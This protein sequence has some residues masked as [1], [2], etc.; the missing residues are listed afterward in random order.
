VIVPIPCLRDNYAYLVT[1]P[2]TFATAIVDP[3]ESA[4]VLA[5][6]AKLS[7]PPA[8]I[9]CTHHHPDHVGGNEELVRE[10]GLTRVVGHV[11]DKG[12]IP[13][14]TVFLEDGD[15]FT[16]GSLR[17][18]VLHVPGHTSGAIA[19]VVEGDGAPAV[20]TGDTMFL[21]GCGRLFEGT[22]AQMFESFRR[23]GELPAETRIY[24]GHE[25]TESNLK[26]AAHV[27]P[28]NE[29]I[30]EARAATARLR[31]QGRPT[32][33]GTLADE[34]RINPFLRAAN[35]EELAERRRQKD[36]F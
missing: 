10:L 36:V 18:R 28:D 23:I 20:F 4:P 35:V 12:R 8:E 29:A 34:R 16:L 21:G 7:K 17:V 30:A 24:C 5:A 19:Y 14:Q 33:P 13:C 6:V 32:I 2:V 11:S 31:E 3:S 9:W 1:C 15:A 27:E 25:Y 22:P 26:F